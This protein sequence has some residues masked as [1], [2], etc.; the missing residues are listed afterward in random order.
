V[1]NLAGSGKITIYG[2]GFDYYYINEAR[3][4]RSRDLLE[5]RHWRNLEQEY[6]KQRSKQHK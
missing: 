3:K 6:K 4:E 1:H 5:R 2:K